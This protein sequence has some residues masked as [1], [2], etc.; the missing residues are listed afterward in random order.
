MKGKNKHFISKGKHFIK[1]LNI[2]L[3]LFIMVAYN[4]GLFQGY[5]QSYE[6]IIVKSYQQTI[7]VS[8]M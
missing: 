2:I 5:M 8:S 4:L 6:Y 1:F 3:S 7:R